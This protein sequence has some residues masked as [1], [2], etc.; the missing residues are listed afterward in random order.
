M[1][2]ALLHVGTA[3]CFAGCGAL[4]LAA[5]RCGRRAA[6]SDAPP[7][8]LHF[9]DVEPAPAMA[10]TAG[11]EVLDFWGGCRADLLD[12]AEFRYCPEDFR[13]T[14][15]TVQADGS[16]RCMDCQLISGDA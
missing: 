3:A 8:P 5:Q 11:L 14:K 2:S 9:S 16:R 7:T 13:V 4:L 15:Q 6:A 12:D 10:G 1:T